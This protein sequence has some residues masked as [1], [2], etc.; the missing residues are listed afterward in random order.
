MPENYIPPE[1][2]FRMYTGAISPLGQDFADR[3]TNIISDRI[4]PTD[5]LLLALT[6][7]DDRYPNLYATVLEATLQG[8][9][10]RP[11]LVRGVPL[12]G[13][14]LPKEV[15]KE[16]IEGKPTV[17]VEVHFSPYCGLYLAELKARGASEYLYACPTP[18]P[19]SVWELTDANELA[20]LRKDV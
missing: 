16:L 3:V 12:N 19:A 18:I 9:R 7:K 4:K 20:Q 6:D 8:R 5:L 10:Y 11:S 15:T 14:L 17:V 1:Q 13:N 2:H